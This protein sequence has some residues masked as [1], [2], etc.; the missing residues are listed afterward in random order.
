MATLARLNVLLGLE[1]NPFVKA[2]SNAQRTLRT[3]ASQAERAGR[4]MST[5]L[6]APLTLAGRAAVKMALEFDGSLRKI[7]GL[8]GVS[9]EQVDAWRGDLLAMGVEVG[10][11][12]AEL[13]AGLFDVT[14]AGNRGSVALD[15]LRAAS[16]GATAGLGDTKTVAD[17]L[18]STLNAYGAANL[19]AGKATGILVATVREGKTSAETLAPVIGAL[20]PIAAELGISF[21]QL[22]AAIAHLTR[23]N[24]DSAASAT[25]VRN[26]MA[27]LLRPTAQAAHIFEQFGLSGEKLRKMLA[28]RG[29]LATLLELRKRF[30]TNTEALGKAFRSIEAVTGI[31]ALTRDEGRAAI[32]IFEALAGT[33]ERDLVRAFDAAKGSGF[34]LRQAMARVA[35]GAILLGGQILPVIVPIFSRFGEILTK[36]AEAF[37]TWPPYAQRA[38]V[39]LGVLLAAAGP[40]LLVIGAIAAALAAIGSTTAIVAAVVGV[41]AALFVTHFDD[42]ASAVKGFVAAIYPQLVEVGA[43]LRAQWEKVR[44]A[45]AEVWPVVLEI[46]GKVVKAISE[47]WAAYGDKILAAVRVTWTFLKTAIS[48]ALDVILGV[49][50]TVLYAING[51]W[52]KAKDSLLDIGRAIYDGLGRYFN[53]AAFAVGAAFASMAAKV[54]E[55]VLDILR[56]VQRM[57]E[58]LAG[59]LFMSPTLQNAALDGLVKINE[60]I[61]GWEGSIEANRVAA[62]TLNA[63]AGMI[64][65]PLDAGRTKWVEM[66]S[67]VYELTGAV[68]QVADD[69]VGKWS[70][71]TDAMTEK[72][73]HGFGKAW[74]GV[75]GAF[76]EMKSTIEATTITANVVPK[77]DSD[78]LYRQ[79]AELGLEPD[80]LGVLP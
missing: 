69:A 57:T 47:L 73:T 11:M 14:S 3:F 48:N 70:A 23:T 53:A 8:V 61:S 13:A 42:I 76:T 4:Q 2:L 32:P 51:D 52:S 10:K 75:R 19:S 6:T 56:K 60:A 38:A 72:F 33:T 59:A 68:D 27:G 50:K 79:F 40:V 35:G 45:T 64:L 21:D 41:G 1:A 49:T 5:A 9:R 37:A 7:V 71:A 29:L 30:G 15:I 34:A 17:A 80:D 31:L 28:E 16:M 74:E 58:A 67:E 54:G 20:L 25:M 78:A 43:F 63:A 12:P 77:V 36:A 65:A 55:Y 22:G 44:A 18:T 24:G 26:I 46:V 62:E 39:V 66:R